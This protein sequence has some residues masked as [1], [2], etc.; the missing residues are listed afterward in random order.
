VVGAVI[1]VLGGAGSHSIRL[2]GVY[3]S[4]H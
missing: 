1:R 2:F 3:A 4:K